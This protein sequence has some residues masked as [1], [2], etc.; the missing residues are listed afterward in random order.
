MIFTK[1][2]GAGN[3][4]ILIE[5]GDT[6]HAWSRIATAMCDRHYGIG[7]DGLLLLMPSGVA[8]FKMRILNADGSESG[9]SGNGL[10]CMIKYYITFSFSDVLI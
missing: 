10:R 4:F 6:E 5:T 7:A 3:D 9:I 2:H 1:M 8:D